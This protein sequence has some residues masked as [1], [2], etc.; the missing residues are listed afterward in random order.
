MVERC[1][2]ARHE[3]HESGS[4]ALKDMQHPQGHSRFIC[5]PVMHRGTNNDPKVLGM[6]MM[7][8]WLLSL[9]FL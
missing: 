4:A 3:Q 6:F 9:T 1:T 5:Q 7:R 8:S 2:T